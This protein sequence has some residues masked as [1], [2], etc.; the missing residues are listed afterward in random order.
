M[1][2]VIKFRGKNQ[3]IGWVIGQLAYGSNEE[4][5]IIEEVEQDNSYGLEEPILCPIIWHR[6]DKNTIGQFTRIIR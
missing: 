6:V 2:R 3:Y 5:Y 1:N 4:V